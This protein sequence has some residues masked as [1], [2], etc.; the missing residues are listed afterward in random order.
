MVRAINE[1]R[2]DCVSDG[3]PRERLIDLIR[4]ILGLMF[5]IEVKLDLTIPRT[6]ITPGR[7]GFPDAV[8]S[9]ASMV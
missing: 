7:T 8:T 6:E 2:T 3:T 4:Q 5:A 1:L 9:S